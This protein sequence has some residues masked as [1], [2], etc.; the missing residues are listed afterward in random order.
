M[1]I[2]RAL[3]LTVVSSITLTVAPTRA[4]EYTASGSISAS[5]QLDSFFKSTAN[6]EDPTGTT[7]Y[8]FGESDSVLTLHAFGSATAGIAGLKTSASASATSIGPFSISRPF[9]FGTSTSAD[10]TWSDFMI[11]GP[12]GP[13][14]IQVSLNL[15]IDGTLST[16]ASTSASGTAMAQALIQM[17][18]R[19]PSND[20]P[21]GVFVQNS[22]NGNAPTVQTSGLLSGFNGTAGNIT[23]PLFDVPVNTPFP[24]ELYLETVASVS[25]LAGDAFDLSAQ[26]TFLNTLKF[27]TNGPVF[28][29][30]SGY[31]V[32]SGTAGITNNV[33]PEASS[34]AFTSLGVVLFALISSFAR[35]LAPAATNASVQ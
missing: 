13:A 34:L 35:S 16:F 10:A 12:T 8:D 33:V 24:L 20:T 28:N 6:G 3:L 14:T 25:S 23:T 19:T 1:T 11:S 15:E 18:V 29:L 32:N 21:G 31:T 5:R 2:R 17:F 22:Q 30:P 9:T 26:L 4:E 27:A 7:Q